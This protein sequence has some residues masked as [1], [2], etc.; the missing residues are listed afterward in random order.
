MDVSW[1]LL[2]AQACVHL[3]V[4][5]RA[6]N[7]VRMLRAKLAGICRVGRAAWRADAAPELVVFYAMSFRALGVPK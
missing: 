7:F 3:R 5:R 4:G 6:A 1:T 2:V